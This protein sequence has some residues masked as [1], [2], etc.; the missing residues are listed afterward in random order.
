M[1]LTDGSWGGGAP[2]PVILAM[3]V[4]DT[5]S[6]RKL[7]EF[8]DDQAVAALEDVHQLVEPA[9]LLGSQSGGRSPR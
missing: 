6:S 2:R 7:G 4:L 8:A 5:P 9:A 3:A 1:A